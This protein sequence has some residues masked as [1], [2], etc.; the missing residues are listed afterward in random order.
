MVKCTQDIEQ[1]KMKKW[2][3]LMSAV[4]DD[5]ALSPIL[6]PMMIWLQSSLRSPILFGCP[7]HYKRTKS[8]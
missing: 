7:H 6:D 4:P 8:K 2:S 1:N 3:Y 5:K